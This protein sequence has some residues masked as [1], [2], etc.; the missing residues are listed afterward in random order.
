MAAKTAYHLQKDLDDDMSYDKQRQAEMAVTNDSELRDLKSH[1]STLKRNIRAIRFIVRVITFGLAI[2]T[3]YSQ[4]HMLYKYE[5][6]KGIIRNNRNPWAK[7]TT[8]WPTIILLTTSSLTVLVSLFLF[9][10]YFRGV[11]HANQVYY[12]YSV[13]LLVA[14]ICTHLGIWIA[15]AVSYRVGK[16][17]KDL[18]GWS[19]SPKAQAIQAVFKEVDFSFLCGIQTGSWAVSVAQVILVVIAAS[20]WI[21]VFARSRHQKEVKAR[22]SLLDPILN[23]ITKSSSR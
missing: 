23:S 14:E 7:G 16:T 1:D 4:A 18:W 13:P 10:S 9:A 8:I 21:L 22:E 15:T 19:C 17:G 2:Y 11:K 5:T 12:R 20:G 3:T 6:T